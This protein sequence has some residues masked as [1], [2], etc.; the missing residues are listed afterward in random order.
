MKSRLALL[1]LSAAIPAQALADPPQLPCNPDTCKP[2]DPCKDMGRC[3]EPGGPIVT[4][5]PPTP[6]PPT[7]SPPPPP[8]ASFAG[9]SQA[10]VRLER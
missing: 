5:A 2:I 10:T 7:P 1:L 3:P 4:P 6:S 9:I 8:S